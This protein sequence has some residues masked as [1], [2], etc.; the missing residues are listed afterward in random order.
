MSAPVPLIRAAPVRM[1]VEFLERAGAPV[2]RLLARARL[3]PRI[4]ILPP[5]TPV[6]WMAASRL[7]EAAARDQGMDDLGIRLGAANDVHQLGAF[8]SFITEPPTLRSGLEALC[9][10]MPA[11]SSIERAWLSPRGEQVDLN[12]Y[13]PHRDAAASEQFTTATLAMYLNYISMTTGPDWYPTV[14][15]LPLRRSPGVR[16]LP[17]LANAR[18]ELGRPWLTFTL[19]ASTLDRVRPQRRETEPRVGASNWEATMPASDIGS[20]VQ[21]VVVTLLPDGYPEIALVAASVGMSIRTL[22]RRLQADGLT[23]GDVVAKARFTEARRLLRDPARKIIDVALDLGYSDPS[24][25]T[26]A[27]ERWAGM[28][29]RRFRQ[30]A[31]DGTGRPGS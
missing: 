5:E 28:P 11:Y 25:F 17:R 16:S 20:A 31:L 22:Q 2:E 10:L 15:G 9:R 27:F 14:V 21:Q 19:A 1:T 4:R 7:L 23:F 26:R 30:G 24:H 29:P 18:I 3:T 12:H 13:I 6:S 8:G